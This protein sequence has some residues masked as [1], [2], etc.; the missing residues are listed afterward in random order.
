MLLATEELFSELPESTEDNQ[1]ALTP[2]SILEA[3][4]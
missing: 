4:S 1:T 3:I 2:F